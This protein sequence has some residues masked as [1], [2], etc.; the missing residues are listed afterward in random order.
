MTTKGPRG[1][2]EMVS[3]PRMP[4]CLLPRAGPG[5]CLA[6]VLASRFCGDRRKTSASSSSSSPSSSP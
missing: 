3:A 1:A 5:S 4:D 6:W 2:V